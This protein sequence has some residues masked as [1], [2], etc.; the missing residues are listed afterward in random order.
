MA[1]TSVTTRTNFWPKVHGMRQDLALKATRE[2][3]QAIATLIAAMCRDRTRI[4]H[5][6]AYGKPF[7]RYTWQTE[8]KKH[9]ALGDQAWTEASLIVTRL[10]AQLIRAHESNAPP[11]VITAIR[12]QIGHFRSEITR[13]EREYYGAIAE[14]K[15]D[16]NL[17]ETGELLNSLEAK[18]AGSFAKV[19]A[20]TYYGRWNQAGTKQRQ[21]KGEKAT[22]RLPPRPF[23]GISDAEL[24]WLYEY[25]VAP[26]F[27]W[28][29][30]ALKAM[31]LG[32]EPETRPVAGRL[33]LK[34]MQ[35]KPQAIDERRT[36]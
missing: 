17:T 24:S 6:D 28:Y 7:I 25:V 21:R 2:E 8:K 18:G 35:H 26:I 29:I 33:G 16:V 1:W 32:L 9:P 13:M 10:G 12:K 3:Y 34:A 22:G 23:V 5:L 14:E 31:L 11:N 36:A 27:Q 20:I 15:N 19:K 30:E 4:Y